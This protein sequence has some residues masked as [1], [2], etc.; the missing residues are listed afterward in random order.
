[1]PPALDVRPTYQLFNVM[2]PFESHTDTFFVYLHSFRLH[3]SRYIFC[4]VTHFLSMRP[5]Q[6]LQDGEAP[7]KWNYTSPRR[8]LYKQVIKYNFTL[9]SSAIH[10][11]FKAIGGYECLMYCFTCFG[12]R[13]EN[14]STFSQAFIIL[15]GDFILTL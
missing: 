10:I 4:V 13:T 1:M 15:L 11:L 14:L 7:K 12:C 2:F 3:K 9:Y 8:L 5:I 6:C